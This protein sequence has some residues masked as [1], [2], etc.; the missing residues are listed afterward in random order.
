MALFDLSREARIPWRRR[1]CEVTPKIDCKEAGSASSQAQCPHYYTGPAIACRNGHTSRACQCF[2]I[3]VAR[4]QIAMSWCRNGDTD[5][6]SGNGDSKTRPK[7][8]C[9]EFRCW[10]HRETAGRIEAIVA[11]GAKMGLS[12]VAPRNANKARRFDRYSGQRAGADIS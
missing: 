3:C 4:L 12:G 9:P 7:I 5:T 1:A 10:W 11:A 6:S 2:V 8:V